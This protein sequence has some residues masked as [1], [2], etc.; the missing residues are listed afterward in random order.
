MLKM[1]VL[2]DGVSLQELKYPS[3][4]Q[5]KACRQ[6]HIDK[7]ED[8]KEEDKKEEDKKEEDKK[9]EDKKEEDKKEED[10]KEGDNP[11]TMCVMPDVITHPHIRGLRTRVGLIRRPLGIGRAIRKDVHTYNSE[12][13]LNKEFIMDIEV[14]Y[15]EKLDNENG[16]EIKV[17]FD[18]ANGMWKNGWLIDAVILE[19]I[20]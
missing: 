12:N 17:K 20:V 13:K 11:A 7:K 5:V 2:I 19:K 9:E 18:H 16:H 4:E 3:D 14:I 8:K 15:D 1:T 6:S 10:K